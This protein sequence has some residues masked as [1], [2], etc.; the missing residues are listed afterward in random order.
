MI[1]R[2]YSAHVEEQQV[3][4]TC[5]ICDTSFFK[6]ADK[7][8]VCPKCGAQEENVAVSTEQEEDEYANQ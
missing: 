1:R 2:Q 7:P 8:P 3:A 4:Y 6:I 5:L